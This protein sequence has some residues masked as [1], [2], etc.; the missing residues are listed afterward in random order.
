EVLQRLQP[1]ELHDEVLLRD[2]LGG[3]LPAAWVE[4]LLASRASWTGQLRFDVRELLSGYGPG[5]PLRAEITGYRERGLTD[6]LDELAARLEP[7][8]RGPE[9][10]VL[11][12]QGHFSAAAFEA[13]LADLPGD[14]RE[15]LAEAIARN[16]TAVPLLETPP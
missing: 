6:R 7:L 4:L 11:L 9:V 16:P 15:R 5:S 13:L 10:G 1:G 8:L 12:S 2:L 3:Y 14:H